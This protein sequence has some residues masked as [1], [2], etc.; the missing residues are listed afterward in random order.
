MV[1]KRISHPRYGNGIV[2]NAWQNFYACPDCHDARLP[3]K[4]HLR[5]TARNTIPCPS[6]GSLTDPIPVPCD[7]TYDIKFADGKVHSLHESNFTV[8]W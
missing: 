2:I 7:G 4:R 1:G 3:Y 5:K 8:L 6:C